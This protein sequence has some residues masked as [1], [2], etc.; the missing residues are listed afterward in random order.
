M[1]ALCSNHN[2]SASHR[3]K[4]EVHG[5]N[6]SAKKPKATAVVLGC[7]G[8]VSNGNGTNGTA[9]LTEPRSALKRVR[10]DGEGGGGGGGGGDSGG[11]NKF[12]KKTRF[13]LSYRYV[14]TL[15]AK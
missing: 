8:S 3:A 2:E 7:N 1:A 9:A 4:V 12:E 14:L 15:L 5:Q 6:E 13:D 10:P 11:S